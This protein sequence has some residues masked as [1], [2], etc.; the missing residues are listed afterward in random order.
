MNIT[1]E[2]KDELEDQSRGIEDW[3]SSDESDRFLLDPLVQSCNIR[4]NSQCVQ[5]ETA[6][7]NMARSII[8]RMFTHLE[9]EL[10]YSGLIQQFIDW[11]FK[12][13]SSQ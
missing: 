9:T 3:R 4:R 2:L 11:L 7:I 6:H 5:M 1:R 10:I 12:T 13:G 8:K